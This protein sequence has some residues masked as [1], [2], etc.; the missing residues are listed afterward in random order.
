M[1]AA[2]AWQPT[3]EFSHFYEAARR[4]RPPQKIHGLHTKLVTLPALSIGPPKRRRRR[5][6]RRRR[7]RT[8]MRMA[9]ASREP[10][11]SIRSPTA[12]PAA[13]AGDPSHTCMS[14]V[15]DSVLCECDVS[16]RGCKRACERATVHMSK[17]SGVHG[18]DHLLVPER[19]RPIWVDR[20]HLIHNRKWK[21]RNR[22]GRRRDGGGRF[23]ARASASQVRVCSGFW[24]A[25]TLG[26]PA[27]IQ[28]PSTPSAQL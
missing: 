21:E 22:G 1:A 28:R 7:L 18:Q 14:I 17:T 24:A 20:T 4:P 11:A 19:P 23:C 10:M 13:A 9:S 16:T 2:I 5:R 15:C 6:R 25:L 27:G 8:W 12:S 3:G 26:R